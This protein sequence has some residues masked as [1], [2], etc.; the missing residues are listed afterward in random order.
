[1]PTCDIYLRLSDARI[2][3]AF[4]G[5][6]AKLRTYADVLGWTVHRV[7]TENDV[8]PDGK[9][10]PASAWKR[11]KVLTPSGKVEHRVIRPGFRDV[12][13]DIATG[14]VNALLGEDLDR[15]VR[16]PRDMEDLLDICAMTKASVKSIS[17]SLKITDGGDENEKYIARIMVAGASKASGD[18]SRRVADD[19][20]RNWGKSY[21][22]GPRPYGFVAA[23]ETEKYHRTLIIVPDEA[24]ILRKATDDILNKDISLR[25]IANDLRQ[26]GVLNTKGN[27]NW[28]SQSL[29]HVLTKPSIAGLA[30]HKGNLRDAPWDAIL[31]RDVWEKLCAFLTDESRRTSHVGTEPKWLLSNIARCGICDNGTTVRASGRIGATFYTCREGYHLKRRAH[32]CDAWVERNITAYIS[33]NALAILK[34][35]PRPDIDTTALRTEAKKLRERKAAQMRMH[36]LGDIDDA[37]LAVGLR[38]IRDRLAIID[39]QLAKADQPDP[40]PEFRRHGPT[41]QIWASLSLPR[42]RAIINMLADITILPTALRGRAGFDPGSVRIV[43]KETGNVLDVRDWPEPAEKS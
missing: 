36:A 37:D 18:T 21:A 32:Y 42:K 39:V 3:E 4:D 6:E 12:L 25:A 1:M 41:R 17:G 22:G 33:Q 2:E 24:D 19:R 26:R 5:R 10:K 43:L 14:R 34:P 8:Y 11:R 28:T 30:V 7:I 31:E 29:K 40:I 9:P 23:Q 20:E 27:T 15:I 16:D 38:V 13:D 35:E